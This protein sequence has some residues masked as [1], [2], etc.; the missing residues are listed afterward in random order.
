MSS[1]RTE[2]TGGGAGAEGVAGAG[3]AGGAG[4][5]AGAGAA[6]GTGAVAASTL[7]DVTM[8]QMGVSVAEGTVIGWRVQ[9]GDRIAA[10]ETICDISTD[11]IDTEVPAP[12]GGVVTEILVQTET[13]VPVGTVLARIALEGEGGADSPATAPIPTPAAS[14]HSAS[15]ADAPRRPATDA[16][17]PPPTDARP[18]LPPMH[19]KT[20]P[21]GIPLS[22]GAWQPSTAS[23]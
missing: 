3:A 8:P 15:P 12:V 17:P 21:R 18:R 23:T 5:V 7:V 16:S 14:R 6:G 9:P 13:T 4:A 11:K 2:G 20:E 10:D 19:H 22:Y 1:S